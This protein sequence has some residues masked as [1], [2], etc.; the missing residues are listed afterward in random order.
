VRFWDSSAIVPLLIS[1]PTTAAASGELEL[2]PGMFV[3]WSTEV[4]C[5]SAITRAERDRLTDPSQ[6]AQALG[7]MASLRTAWVEV[8]QSGPLRSTAIR[9][10]RTHEL[11]AADALQLAAALVAAD[12]EPASLRF[13][14]LDDRLGLAA[15]REGFPVVRFGKERA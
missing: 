3:W 10:T 9:L 7:A 15:E 5:V 1:E 12:N 4:E 6:T 13:V 2:D 11:R 8:E 14:T